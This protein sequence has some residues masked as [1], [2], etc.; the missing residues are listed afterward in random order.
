MTL[1]TALAEGAERRAALR[2]VPLRCWD[3]RLR[4]SEYL[5]GQLAEKMP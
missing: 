4:V 2:S 5:E 3:A 1:V